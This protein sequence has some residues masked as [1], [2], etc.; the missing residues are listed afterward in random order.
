MDAEQIKG[1]LEVELPQCDV[2]VEG[3]EGKFWITIVG[4]VF[5]GLNAVKR[6]Q[7]VYKIL[8]EHI[9]SGAVH[10]VTMR[11]YTKAEAGSVD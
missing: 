1:M 5:D 11:L 6:Q 7:K 2:K 4:D 8:N 10:A 9:S 3:A